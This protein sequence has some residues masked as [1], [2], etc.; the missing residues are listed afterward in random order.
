[1]RVSREGQVVDFGY[2]YPGTPVLRFDVRSLT[3]SRPQPND[4]LTFTPNREGL[5]IDGWLNAA[6]PT[7]NG[8]AL[9][10]VR[11]DVARSLAILRT[12]NASSLA[13][14]SPLQRSTTREHKNGD[15]RAE[16]RFLLST[17]ARMAALWSRPTT[18]V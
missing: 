14:A 8:R 13:R 17:P 12:P 3:L 2:G 1:M 6:N 18:A 7:L 11:Y 10:F 9:P 15:G 5:A 16:T 4:G